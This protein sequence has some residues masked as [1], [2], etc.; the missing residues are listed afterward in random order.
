MEWVTHVGGRLISVSTYLTEL[1][2]LLGMTLRATPRLRGPR[3]RVIANVT[4]LQLFYTGFQAVQPVTIGAVALGLL[5][6][7]IS[8][9]YLPADYLQGVA[10]VV[11]VREVV[12]LLI[13][14][15]LIGRSGTAITIDVANMK[16]ND[17]L[18]ALEVMAIPVAEFVLFPRV[19]GVVLASVFLQ[20]YAQIAAL[21][22]GYW[23]AAL[24]DLRMPS[25]PAW[26]LVAG[27]DPA[28]VFVSTVKVLLFGLVIALTAVQ[29][30]LH[31]GRSRREIPI[32]TSRA[33]VRS[34]LLCFV[35]NTVVSLAL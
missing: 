16:L 17:E 11:I 19:V 23:G 29:H 4:L 9:D 30:G 35:L 26:D 1:V 6:L 15:L 32:V 33:V 24:V 12:P 34:L 22:G 3:G 18:S 21:V 14:F 5:V 20:F 2:G 10:S 8:A 27:I 13:A 25:Y 7:S 31:V 28:D